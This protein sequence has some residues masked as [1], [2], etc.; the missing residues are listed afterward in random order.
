MARASYVF[1]LAKILRAHQRQSMNFSNE[2]VL[3]ITSR[4]S[5]WGDGIQ[6]QGLEP[7]LRTD[8]HSASQEIPYCL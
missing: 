6:L 7:F 5:E 2:L 4:V 8:C 1:T 3:L